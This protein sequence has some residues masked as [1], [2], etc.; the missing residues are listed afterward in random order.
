MLKTVCWNCRG[1]GSLS[2]VDAIK[3]IIKSERPDILFLQETKMPDV[4]AMALSC[5]FW[6]NNKGKAIS[7]KGAY[8]GITTRILCKLLVK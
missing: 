8:G 1:L 6:K 4:E 3:E 5:H 7:S 2:K